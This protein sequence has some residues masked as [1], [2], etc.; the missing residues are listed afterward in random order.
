MR[1]EHLVDRLAEAAVSAPGPDHVTIQPMTILRDTRMALFQHPDSL[2]EF[3]PLVLGPRARLLVACGIKRVVWNRIRSEVRFEVSV[4]ADGEGEA[5]VLSVALDPRRR[6]DDRRWIDREVDLARFAGRRVRLVFRTSV[7]PRGDP[8]YAWAG[9]AE[10]RVL[11]EA[12]APPRPARSAAESP[13]VLVVSADALR[14]DYLGCAGHP[15][16]R[17]P[18]LD[19]LAKGGVR[20]PHARAQTGTNI[21]SYASFLTGQHV[22]THG[23][24]SEWGRISPSLATLPV[25]LRAFGYH[26]VFAASDSE[27]AEHDNGIG[28]LFAEQ[29]VSLGRPGQDGAVTTRRWVEW[30]D[31]RPARPSLVW[32]E[33]FDT[34]PPATPPEP[35]RS[36]YYTGDPTRPTREHRVADVARIRGI[37]AVQEIEQAL[38][39]L[40]RGR[41]DVIITEKLRATVALWRGT[42]GSGPDLAA[43]LQAL[44]ATARRGL[45]VPRLAEWLERQVR[46][47]DA[48]EVP[49]EAVDW[50]EHL[51]PMLKEIES[52][53]TSWLEGVV[54]FRYPISQYMAGIS[55]FDHNVGRLV[56]ALEERGLAERSTVIVFSPHGEVLGERGVYFHHHTLMEASLRVPLIWKGAGGALRVPGAEIGGVF[57]LIDVFPTLVE[58]LGLPVPG[59]LAGVSRW[60]ALRD[61][62]AIPP[63]ASMAVNNHGSML[64]V[65]L[66]PWK[67][68]TAYRDHRVSE[69][70]AWRAGDRALYDLRSSPL[71]TAD[72]SARHPEVVKEL[73]ARLDEWCRAVGW[74]GTAGR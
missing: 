74:V 27:L 28:D 5:R 50:L 57:D 6:E 16:V 56:E 53:I 54:D 46:A 48:G 58:S 44:P 30:L 38:P 22:P 10:P 34:H 42:P 2:V 51:L 43:H 31:R 21:G 29:I 17:T 1:T 47:M 4:V 52:D 26:T 36:M 32:L 71:D 14:A 68:L 73:A 64:S 66:P 37:E 12:P 33:Y 72:V 8:S 60:G 7:P 9:W 3:P 67:L 24:E 45:T 61:G 41:P 65:T 69:D 35:F 19:A 70:W 39:A 15:G 62:D 11:H 13:L 63:H 23:L 25:Y 18:H 20:V 40:R 55:Y 59:G 49:R